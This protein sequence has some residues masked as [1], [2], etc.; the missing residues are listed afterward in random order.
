MKLRRPEVIG[1]AMFAMVTMT[2]MMHFV[3]QL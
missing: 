1:M 2:M 3:S